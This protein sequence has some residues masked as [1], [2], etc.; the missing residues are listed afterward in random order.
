MTDTTFD[1]AAANKLIAERIEHATREELKANLR[2]ILA[3]PLT[4]PADAKAVRAKMDLISQE[5][6]HSHTKVFSGGVWRELK[7]APS[8]AVLARRQEIRAK[9]EKLPAHAP[10][11][12]RETLHRELSKLY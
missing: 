6:G 1:P 9:L 3:D 2:T 10:R 7:P 5:E 12:E 8:P 11:R 4:K